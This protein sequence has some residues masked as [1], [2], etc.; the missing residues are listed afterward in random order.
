MEAVIKSIIADWKNVNPTL[1]EKEIGSLQL[2]YRDDKCG[3]Y[4][5]YFR[6][7]NEIVRIK[8]IK[9]PETKFSKLVRH[10][11]TV[12]G[13]SVKDTWKIIELI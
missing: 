12:F 5:I 1:A 4:T 9:N 11:K 7:G 2:K 8:A 10:L 6:A 13:L 3:I